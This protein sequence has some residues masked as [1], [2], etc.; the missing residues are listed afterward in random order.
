MSTRGFD[1]FGGGYATKPPSF[2]AGPTPRLMLPAQNQQMYENPTY[3]MTGKSGWQCRS[4][5]AR[6]ATFKGDPEMKKQHGSYL[7]W[8]FLKIDLQQLFSGYHGPVC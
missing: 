2:A 4:S 3:T 7:G 5:A 6:Q 8:N 1:D